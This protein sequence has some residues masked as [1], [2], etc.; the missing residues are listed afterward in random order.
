MATASAHPETTDGTPAVLRESFFCISRAFYVYVGLLERLLREHELA[1]HVRPGMG[2]VLFALFEQDDVIIQN[3][4]QRTEL[5]RTALTRLVRQM[6]KSKLITRRRDTSDG[7]AVRIRLTSAGRSLEG[8]CN[9]V[10]DEL[11]ATVEHDISPRQLQAVK[12]GLRQMTRN[13]RE[14][15]NS[16]E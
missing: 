5:S 8:R 4:V 3:L 15:T 13:M 7:R 11:R 12:D 9:D 2:H 16:L 14:A 10:I 1:D 6:E